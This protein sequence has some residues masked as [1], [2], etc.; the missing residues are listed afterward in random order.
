GDDARLARTHVFLG[1]S[2]VTDAVVVLEIL[3][4]SPIGIGTS[5]GWQPASAA[6]RVT[7]SAGMS[8]LSLNAAPAVEVFQEHAEATGQSFDRNAPLPFF[9]HNLIGIDTGDGYKLR[10]P[11]AV[12]GDGS[13]ACAAEVPEGITAHIMGTSAASAADAAAIAARAA[14]TG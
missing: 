4:D 6:M 10:V 3:S 1:T 9:L 8:L 11:L 7:E 12:Q 14:L 5:H 13:L 2:A